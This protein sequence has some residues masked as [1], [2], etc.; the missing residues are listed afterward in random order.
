MQGGTI[1]GANESNSSLRNTSD[2]GNSNP[3]H[4]LYA[5]NPNS[6]TVGDTIIGSETGRIDDTIEVVNGA[7]Q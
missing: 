5:V 4:A 7:W 6:A 1:F 3:G 2:S